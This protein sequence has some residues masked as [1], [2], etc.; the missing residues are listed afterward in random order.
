MA[1]F[2]LLVLA[3]AAY[4]ITRLITRDDFPPLLW[5]RDRVVGGWRPLTQK[6][7]A[8]ARRAGGGGL[9]QFAPTQDIE[10]QGHSRY[11]YRASWVPEWLAEL[12]GCPWCVSAY[13][14][15]ALVALTDVT[16]GVPRP[17]LTAVAVWALA[18]LLA[19]RE[20]A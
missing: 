1:W 11:V 2:T 19:S 14:S 6:E 9:K 8:E 4:R 5:L 17:W 7:W 18:A 3:L 20:W 15:G 12:W 10:G 13:V 16:V